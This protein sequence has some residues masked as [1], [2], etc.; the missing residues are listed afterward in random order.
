MKNFSMCVKEEM[1]LLRDVIYWTLTVLGMLSFF[2]MVQL[3]CGGGFSSCLFS[4]SFSKDYAVSIGNKVT[5]S[6]AFTSY[7]TVSTVE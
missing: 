3:G 7:D 4:P 5:Y 6:F 1:V 2:V